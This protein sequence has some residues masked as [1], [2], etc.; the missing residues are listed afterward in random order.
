MVK[1]TKTELLHYAD[2]L[3]HLVIGLKATEQ[4]DADSIIISTAL[5]RLP[6][7][8]EEY[9]Q[10]HTESDRKVMPIDKLIHSSDPE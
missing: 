10:A 9:W 7:Q 5:Q 8:V 6:R 2:A 3:E 4:Y 1:N